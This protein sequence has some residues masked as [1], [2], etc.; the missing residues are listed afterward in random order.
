MTEP[1]RLT[2]E[3]A[4]PPERAFHLWTAETT[5]WWPVDHTATGAEGSK[6]VFE[7]AVGGGVYEV[8]AA[9]ERI[10][11]GEVVAW[12][13]PGHLAYL[14]H[15]RTDRADATEVRI[16]FVAVGDHSARIDIEHVG[17]ERLGE[18]DPDRRDANRQGW[19]TLL[20]HFEV[21]ARE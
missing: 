7:P 21:A 11:W 3:V 12:D 5:R 2:F 20:P 19:A 10:D 14:W 9:G 17:W 15:L 8:T 6:V 13:P 18:R 16:D 4:C 1:L